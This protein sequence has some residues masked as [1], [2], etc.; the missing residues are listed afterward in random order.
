[1]FRN[2]LREVRDRLRHGLVVQVPQHLV[3]VGDGSGVVQRDAEIRT[4]VVFVA[5]R[6]DRSEHLV[7]VK[8]GEERQVLALADGRGLFE[9]DALKAH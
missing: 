2:P 8:V 7:E 3:P 9:Q 1:M 5:G 4:E 6:R